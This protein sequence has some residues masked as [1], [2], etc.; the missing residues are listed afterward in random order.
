MMTNTIRADTLDSLYRK[1]ISVAMYHGIPA[2]P[3]GFNCR[4]LVGA[5]LILSPQ[6]RIPM[7]KSKARKLNYAFQIIETLQYVFGVMEVDR[8]VF[9]NG[10]M[11]QFVNPKTGEFDGAY[12]PRLADQLSRCCSMLKRDPDS[13][14]AVCTIF[15]GHIDAAADHRSLDVPCTVSFQ[16]LIRD[17]MLHMV[18]N[19]RSNDLFLG[20]PYDTMAFTFIQHCMAAWLGV[21]PG[22]YHHVAGSLH[23]YD[24]DK[25]RLWAVLGESDSVDIDYGVVRPQSY[26]Q[27][28]AQL[29]AFFNRERPNRF[30]YIAG[31]DVELTAPWSTMF[32]IVAKYAWM[33]KT[34][35]KT[36]EDLVYND[37]GE[38]K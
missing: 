15:N 13:R 2:S 22:E 19:M 12:G 6:D 21:K 28:M 10:K 18:V 32:D 7:V 24:R 27:T 36:T 33:K 26:Q 38:K 23:Y 14:Q 29:V 30:G 5:H 35:K 16:F 34:A 1:A 9:Y 11:A 25:D 8:L 3:R 37:K 31:E 20:T 4:E 17:A